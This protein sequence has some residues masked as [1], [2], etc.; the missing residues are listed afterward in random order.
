MEPK[1]NQRIDQF[2]PILEVPVKTCLGDLRLAGQCLAIQAFRALRVKGI[3]RG[4]E[5][6]RPGCTGSLFS[7]I[8]GLGSLQTLF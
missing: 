5:P 4:R 1:F 3:E 2:C 8:H 7:G 6:V